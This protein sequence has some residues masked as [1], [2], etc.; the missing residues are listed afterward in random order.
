MQEQAAEAIFYLTDGRVPAGILEIEEANGHSLEKENA[1]PARNS[2]TIDEF[3][4]QAE[5]AQQCI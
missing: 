4:R 2:D 3:K 5:A 1:L